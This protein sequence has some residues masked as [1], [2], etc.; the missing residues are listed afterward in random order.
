MARFIPAPDLWN[1]DTRAALDSGALRLQ[2]GQWIK[3]G[4]GPLSRF[5]SHN[6]ATGHVTAFHGSGAW[7]TRK[8]RAYVEAVRQAERQREAGRA[9]R[10]SSAPAARLYAVAGAVL[11]RIR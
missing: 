8:L 7:A 5:Y 4:P 11:R 3:C 1:P 6:P 9:A 10:L 2:P